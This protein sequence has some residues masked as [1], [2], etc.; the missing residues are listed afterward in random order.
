M[1]KLITP[2]KMDSFHFQNEQPIAGYLNGLTHTQLIK[3]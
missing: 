2:T 3:V 1:V